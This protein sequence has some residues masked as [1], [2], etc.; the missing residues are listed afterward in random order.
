MLV[1]ASTECF[2]SLPLPDAI[3]KLNDPGIRGV[4]NDWLHLVFAAETAT[5]AFAERARL[6]QGGSFVTRQGHVVTS[7]SVRFYAADA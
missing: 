6:P 1:A 2:G 7:S 3:G 4:L 5:E